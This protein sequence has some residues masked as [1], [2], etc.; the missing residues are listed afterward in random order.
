MK[1][2]FSC[3]RGRLIGSKVRFVIVNIIVFVGHDV[4]QVVQSVG[5]MLIVLD[6]SSYI[7]LCIVRGMYA[8]ETVL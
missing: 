4:E 5:T 8:S 7:I 1:S 6:K 2:S 3:S